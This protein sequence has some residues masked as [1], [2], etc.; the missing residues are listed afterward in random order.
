MQPGTDL[1]DL[2]ERQAEPAVMSQFSSRNLVLLALAQIGILVAAVLGASAAHKWYTTVRT[3]FFEP[4][5]SRILMG[6]GWLGLTLPVAW[7]ALTLYVLRSER[8]TDRAKV[9][10]VLMG[11]LLL[12]IF[13]GAAWLGAASLLLRM[14]VG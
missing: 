8:A 6:Y 13:S 7:L 9:S 14:M 3:P 12:A 4:W 1:W 10:A 2:W 11:F 5:V